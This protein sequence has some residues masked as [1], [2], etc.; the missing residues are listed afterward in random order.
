M[1]DAGVQIPFQ[2][3]QDYWPRVWLS[4]L[5]V[6]TPETVQSAYWKTLTF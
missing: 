6:A 5:I 1:S 2:E 3:E 4:V